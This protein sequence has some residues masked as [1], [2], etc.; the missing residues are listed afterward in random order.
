MAHNILRCFHINLDAVYRLELRRI[1]TLLSLR[2]R[3]TNRRRGGKT[4]KNSAKTLDFWVPFHE[5][6][7]L[8]IHM[9]VCGG[10]W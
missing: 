1:R 6:T 8:G 9:C 2:R 7:Y 4:S 10:W 5:Y 3:K